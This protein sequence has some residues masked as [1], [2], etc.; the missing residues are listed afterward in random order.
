MYAQ[1]LDVADLH[2]AYSCLMNLHT[3]KCC[4]FSHELAHFRVSVER[5]R[6]LFLGSSSGALDVVLLG[7][8][9]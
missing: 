7:P 8:E 9:S 1:A 2:E 5:Q 6:L 4:G 3:W